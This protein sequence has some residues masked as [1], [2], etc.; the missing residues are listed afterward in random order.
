MFENQLTH[1]KL[2]TFCFTTKLCFAV[3]IRRAR[4]AVV[5]KRAR[6]RP[7]IVAEFEPDLLRRRLKKARCSVLCGMNR[8]FLVT[9]YIFNI[10][11]PLQL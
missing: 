1:T 5:T 6:L 2:F 4:A 8:E 3:P 7:G 9:S 11:D 10:F